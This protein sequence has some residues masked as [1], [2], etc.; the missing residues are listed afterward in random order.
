MEK[1]EAAFSFH[2]CIKII[3]LAKMFGIF[4]Q[5]VTEIPKQN[6]YKMQ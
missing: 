3:A 2:S 1:V 6:F 4:P 5:Y